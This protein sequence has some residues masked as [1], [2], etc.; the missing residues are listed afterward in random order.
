[1]FR[2]APRKYGGFWIFLWVLALMV[3]FFPAGKPQTGELVHGAESNLPAPL[4]SGG[5]IICNGK[6]GLAIEPPLRITTSFTIAVKV[7]LT[8]VKTGAVIWDF[9]KNANVHMYLTV[10]SAQNSI[11]F[12]ITTKGKKGEQYIDAPG[13]L[14]AGY[15]QHLSIV[16]QGTVGI[17]YLNGAEA[18]RN[19]TLTLSPADFGKT[20][21]N[22][23]GQSQNKRDQIQGAL[24]QFLVFDRALTAS[25]IRDL[26]HTPPVPGQNLYD[27]QWNLSGDLYAHDPVM[28]K[29]GN[30]WYLFYTG[31]GI[32]FK[33]SDDGI[34]W[35][36]AGHVLDQNPEWMRKIVPT[37]GGNIWAP[38]ISFYQGRYYLYYSK[39]MFGTNTSVIGL[40]TNLTLDPDDP[41][42]LWEDQ[43]PVM[44]SDKAKDYN[45]I[46][47]NLIIDEAGLPWL[48]F[49]SFWSG[50]KLVK[51]D[52][53]TMKPASGEPL[54]ALAAR[55]GNTAVEAPFLT[56]RNGYYYLFVSFDF[57]CRGV[58]SDYKIMVGRSREI[59]GPYLDEEEVPMLEGGGTL[60]DETGTRFKG[61][62]HPAVYQSADS[63][64]LVNH[65]YDA[66]K[67]GAATLQIR[68]LYWSQ[69]AE[70][71]EGWPSL[72]RNG[73]K[74]GN[75]KVESLKFQNPII[76]QRA[77]PWVYRHTDGY[78]YFSASV[79]EYDRIELRRAKTI[80]G[81]REA[82][83]VI[84]WKKHSDGPMSAH[85]WA[86]E[87]H[88]IEGKW[89]IY[90]ATATTDSVFNHRVYVLENESA[91]PLAGNWVE[92]G[93]LK[94]NWESFTLDATSFE[95]RGVRYL[96]W[97]QKDPRI[98]GNSNLYIAALSNPWTLQGPQVMISK[99]EYPWETIGFWVN[100][101]PAVIKKN[102]R[103]FISYSASATDAN[104]CMG[105][106]TALDT[107]DL[108]DPKSWTKAGQPV[109]RTSEENKQYGPGHNCF[110]VSEDGSADV[111]IYHA[112][113]Y[114][115]IQGDPLYDPNRH[116]RAQ[117]L[118][119]NEDG[120]PNF[121][122][123]VADEGKNPSG[124]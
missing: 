22:Y 1:M 94:M 8:A 55:P 69:G 39:S 105:L 29:Q 61:P 48:S 59:T 38:D 60:I 83:P 54:W 113:N 12:A 116:T 37:G 40:L 57:C 52:P 80:Q 23:I 35:T 47:P 65:A 63:V 71:E 95:H 84:V 117:H 107:S 110:T 44:S 56:Y 124:Q 111:M 88:Y 6:K 89:Y 91:N 9:G 96:V 34:H 104:Y 62:G 19:E 75:S 106:L 92:K 43:G 53:A 33:K 103:I 5:P 17:L 81:L 76:K 11:R 74:A 120:T 78:Y 70:G 121:G 102:G 58:N 66:S 15:W 77:D 86:P 27:I 18:G 90:F 2:A 20:V 42:Y 118:T 50:I 24:D 28:A 36:D 98:F 13:P 99:P 101:G 115:K 109:F 87:I 67:N 112:R 97:A 3:G 119:W 41:R 85:I 31:V 26:A 30:R 51:L 79:P 46:D 14:A 45:C 32:P 93:Q 100:E 21:R 10:K 7:K 4:W 25:Q 122:E 64:V 68:P 108:L 82:V 123:P 16:K 73:K 49:G 114:P 72:E